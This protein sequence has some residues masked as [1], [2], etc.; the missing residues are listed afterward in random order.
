MA[1]REQEDMERVYFLLALAGTWGAGPRAGLWALLSYRPVWS[2]RSGLCSLGR[3]FADGVC[4][5]GWAC[6]QSGVLGA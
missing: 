2:E 6:W 4:K 3:W 1:S 5:T